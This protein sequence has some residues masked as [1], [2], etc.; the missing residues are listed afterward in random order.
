VGD[1]EAPVAAGVESTLRYH[2][3]C[4]GSLTARRKIGIKIEK[5]NKESKPRHKRNIHQQKTIK[6]IY[7]IKKHNAQIKYLKQ[8]MTKRRGKVIISKTRFG[9]TQ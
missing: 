8:Y 5:N 4:I 1:V 2:P 7:N 9:K 3:W 6:K